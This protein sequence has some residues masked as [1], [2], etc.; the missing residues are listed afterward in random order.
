MA[1]DRINYGIDLGT[2]NSAIVRMQRGAPVVIKNDFQGDTTPSAVAFGRG[3][4]IRVGTQAHNQLRGDRLRT[5]KLDREHCSVFVE[6]KRTMGTNHRYSASVNTPEGFTSEAL[7]AEVLKELRRYVTAGDVNAA[8]VA[9]PA[10]FTVPQQQA[11]LRAAELAG[12]RQC[13]LLQEPVAAA[14]AYG[15]MEA[16]HSNEKWLVFDFGGGTF[17][18]A[19]ALAEDGQ[20]SVKD[21]EGDNYLGGKDLDRAVVEEIILEAVAQDVDIHDYV[22]GD[23][24]R[25][26]WLRDALKY[27][28]EQANIRLSSRKSH[29][30]ESDLGDIELADG[31][32]IELDFEITRKRLRPVVGPIFQ[33][34]IDK[35]KVLMARHGLSG[36]DLD[37]L[38]LVGGPTYSPILQQMLAEQIRPPSTSVDPMTVVAQ[39]AALYA[40]T[41]A[42]DSNLGPASHRR[43]TSAQTTLRLEVGY[44]ATSISRDE[45][46]TVKWRNPSDLRRLGSLTVELYRT[47]TGW[48]SGKHPLT[49]HGALFELELEE[50]RANVF[51]LVVTTA[52]GDRVTTH[53]SE[54]AI[55]HGTKVTG[56]PLP[57]N[58]GVEVWDKAGENRVLA[59]L[60]GAEKSKS[61]PVTGTRTGLSTH[62]QIRPGV[63]GDRLL[64]RIYE[65]GADAP[66]V[67]VVLCEHVVSLQL[68]G[69]QV[70]RVIPAGTTF[71][72]TVITQASSAV[73]E[74]VRLLFPTLDDE[75]YELEIPSKGQ[76]SQTEWLADELA[77]ARRRIASMRASRQA[78]GA[79]LDDIESTISAAKDLMDG[80]GSDTD[81]RIQA[82]SRLKE[83][84]RG[85]YK[86]VEASAWP[87]AEA[88]LDE[89]WVDLDRANREEGYDAA[90]REMQEARRRLAQVKTSQDAGLARE[91]VADFR[92]LTF[93]LKRCEWSKEVINWARWQFGRIHWKNPAQARQAV[94]EGM[95]AMLADRPCPEL[96][97]HARQILELV[98][99]ESEEDPR[100]PVPH[101]DDPAR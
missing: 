76:A 65:G 35:A 11:T 41:V 37:A 60:K 67:P 40:S 80:A 51:D 91:L 17:D 24:R 1:S 10:A 42:L 97:D 33:R 31:R 39:G 96:L 25:A 61:L 94:D 74:V 34:A 43:N 52:R 99:Q 63:S 9:I 77:E 27:W 16:G 69:D 59:P 5:L 86:L 73:P 56:S 29:P 30:V 89:A 38:I 79:E 68:T 46:L 72:L 101:L 49:E 44:E 18:A 57:N 62:A 90:R 83:A 3:G 48:R 88:E 45:F 93:I 28:A 6:F 19:L 14:M 26:I 32:E 22:A 36:S 20:I 66:G 71:E 13:H 47:G 70:N 53:P 2:T 12:L 64:I 23:S 78:D 85:L 84:L 4:R 92:R 98:V 21:T 54:I 81:A 55:I 75:E 100:P 95:R 8:V 82:N 15:L 58:L 50:N 7:S 87:D